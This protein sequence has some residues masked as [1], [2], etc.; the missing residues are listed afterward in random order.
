MN[1]RNNVNTKRE[2]ASNGHPDR[3][4][5]GTPTPGGLFDLCRNSNECLLYFKPIHKSP[6]NNPKTQT[7][8]MI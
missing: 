2:E 4:E 8:S 6:T 3:L 5:L 7:Y 1:C